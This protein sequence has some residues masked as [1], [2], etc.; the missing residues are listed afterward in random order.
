M[1]FYHDDR[2]SVKSAHPRDAPQALTMSK[3]LWEMWLFDS[4]G[5]RRWKRI[6]NPVPPEV[7]RFGGDPLTSEAR[8]GTFSKASRRRRTHAPPSP[9]C[10]SSPASAPHPEHSSPAA[11]CT[12]V[13]T[14]PSPPGR[15]RARG[16]PSEPGCACT[17]A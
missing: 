11:P 12:L 4:K 8:D 10:V 17:G 16:D 3:G 2:P 14:I 7:P 15:P 6:R 9:S 5:H 1:D 13:L